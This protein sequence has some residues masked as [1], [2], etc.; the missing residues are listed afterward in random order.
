MEIATPKQVLRVAGKFIGKADDAQSSLQS[1]LSHTIG[2]Y[3]TE[4]Y[5]G[6]IRLDDLCAPAVF[7]TNCR[8]PQHLRRR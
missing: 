3:R 1:S 6:E 4:P 8:P 5:Q 7:V 2:V